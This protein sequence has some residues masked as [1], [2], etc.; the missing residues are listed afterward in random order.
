MRK[1][2][3]PLSMIV[4][5][6]GCGDIPPPSDNELEIAAKHCKSDKACEVESKISVL[7]GAFHQK[8][9]NRSLNGLGDLASRRDDIVLEARKQ[10]VDFRSPKWECRDA[11]AKNG[12]EGER[13]FVEIG[14]LERR[15][16]AEKEPKRLLLID[17]INNPYAKNALRQAEAK[18]KKCAN[19]RSFR[20]ACVMEAIKIIEFDFEKTCDGVSAEIDQVLRGRDELRALLPKKIS[21]NRFI[22]HDPWYCR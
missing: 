15:S 10:G 3:A 14:D 16:V 6:G 22:T 9:E 5:L 7:R 1:I 17:T 19:K 20:E 21:H 8:C 4:A 2:L 11:S 18:V 13:E 12:N